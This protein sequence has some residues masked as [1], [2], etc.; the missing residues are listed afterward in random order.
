MNDKKEL[1]KILLV[2]AVIFFSC[3][4]IIPFVV[5]NQKESALVQADL[6]FEVKKIGIS[7]DL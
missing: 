1:L 3:S 5:Y 6:L 2:S 4:Y 7:D